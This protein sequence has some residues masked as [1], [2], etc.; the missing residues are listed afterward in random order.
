MMSSVGMLMPVM[1][2]GIASDTHMMLAQTTMAST[3]MPSGLRPAGVGSTHRISANAIHASAKPIR[4]RA[5]LRPLS[6][7][8]PVINPST[9]LPS[10]E[11]I[12]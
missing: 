5:G 8:L 3:I 9:P 11:A 2:T 10:V 6:R 1:P 7:M 4:V 12:R